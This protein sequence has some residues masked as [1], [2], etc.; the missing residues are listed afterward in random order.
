MEW[1]LEHARIGYV[2]LRNNA[3]FEIVYNSEHLVQNIYVYTYICERLFHLVIHSLV[4]QFHCKGLPSF[5]E[6]LD[7]T[8]V[9]TLLNNAHWSNRRRIRQCKNKCDDYW[10]WS[11]L[12]MLYNFRIMFSSRCSSREKCLLAVRSRGHEKHSDFLEVGIS[13]HEVSYTWSCSVTSVLVIL[14]GTS[15]LPTID[16]LRLEGKWDIRNP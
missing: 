15:T 4:S 9:I 12:I 2:I 5:S 10:L 6:K 13:E 16:M 3:S 7:C 1:E 8:Y 14:W 11:F